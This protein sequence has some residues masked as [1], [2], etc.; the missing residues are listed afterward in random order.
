MST[1]YIETL[2]IQLQSSNLDPYY[3]YAHTDIPKTSR[4]ITNRNA[5]VGKSIPKPSLRRN[6]WWRQTA[7][8]TRVFNGTVSHVTRI[9]RVRWGKLYSQV[10]TGNTFYVHLWFWWEKCR[11]RY[12]CDQQSE[13]LLLV[14]TG[15]CPSE[16]V[17]LD[18]LEDILVILK[19]NYSVI[20]YN[21]L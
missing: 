3:R 15:W 19:F 2:A 11:N 10:V 5:Y 13:S 18:L 9:P 20:I 14:N 6:W 12:F 1:P 21:E 16:L 4:T 7:L 8:N 17:G